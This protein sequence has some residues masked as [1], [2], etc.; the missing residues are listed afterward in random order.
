MEDKTRGGRQW[1]IR[2]P[3]DIKEKEERAKN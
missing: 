1:E 2:D 3:I